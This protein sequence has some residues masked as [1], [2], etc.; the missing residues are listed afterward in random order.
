MLT[1]KREGAIM[2]TTIQISPYI[3]VQGQ[4]KATLPGGRVSICV[5]G[6]DYVGEPVSRGIG[7]R[8]RSDN[9]AQQVETV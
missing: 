7:L 4:V 3:F 1:M 5:D 9:S 2:L 8:T 6:R